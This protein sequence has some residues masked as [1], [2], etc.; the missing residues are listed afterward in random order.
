MVSWH[1][2]RILQ[3]TLLAQCLVV[4]SRIVTRF[5]RE[6]ESQL[7]LLPWSGRYCRG[8][9]GPLLPWS[10]RYCC[11]RVVT[12]V[13]GPLLPWSG[14]YCRGRAVTAVIGPLLP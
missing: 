6:A 13:V 1:E 8:R 5:G 4:L 10:G 11:G 3:V 9:A 2:I 7:E 12:A 14:R